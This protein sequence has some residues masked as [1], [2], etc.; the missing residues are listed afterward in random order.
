M[1]RLIAIAPLAA[2]L[3]AWACGG[4]DTTTPT[5]DGGADA[6]LDTFVADTRPPFDVILPD[7]SL[8]QDI[9][10]GPMCNPGKPFD[11]PTLVAEID[12]SGTDATLRLS[13]DQL[14]AYFTSSRPGGQ[15]DQDVW[16]A[17]RAKVT[18]A[19]SAF[20]DLTVVD[21]PK[22]DRAP[23]LTA[24]GLTLV[25]ESPRIS[26]S[27]SVLVSRR[28][29][30]MSPWGVP[31]GITSLGNFMLVTDPFV[32][33]DGQILYFAAAPNGGDLDLYRAYK[34]GKNYVGAVNV[35]ELNSQAQEELPTVSPDDRLIYLAS[36][37][38]ENG[39]KGGFDIW[40]STRFSINAP[41][42]AP[43]LATEL[44][45]ADDDFPD[46]VSPDGCTLYFHRSQQGGDAGQT[47]TIWVAHKSM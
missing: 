42:T 16:V 33:S 12:T 31:D 18:D 36:A 13:F 6:G 14:T 26:A 20:E 45:S 37:K 44:N 35:G 10:G 17:T 23:S 21:S 5:T 43:T 41:F 25:F 7:T 19:F 47:K 11:P 4:D 9:D 8:Q 24:D 15:G 3:L 38:L 2:L 27:S 39:T 28:A 46:Y 34:S 40:F 29:D 30:T 1:R 22:I 32:R